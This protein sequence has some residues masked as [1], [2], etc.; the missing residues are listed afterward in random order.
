M[1]K[2]V[3]GLTGGIC[4][5]KSVVADMLNKLGCKIVD[6]D[7]ISKKA[8]ARGT[9]GERKLAEIF[10][11]AAVNGVI[12]RRKLKEIVF[13]DKLSLEKLN[14]A[15]HPIIEKKMKA[16]IERAG[17]GIILAVVPLLFE[18][19]FDK[20]CDFSV[21]ISCA[22]EI[23]IARLVKRDNISAELA[24]KILRN[25]FTDEERERRADFVIRN[26]GDIKYL[27]GQVERLFAVLPEKVKENKNDGI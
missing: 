25:Q 5:G 27:F 23:R 7:V 24:E 11:E 1:N 2:I 3:V 20:F 18:T 17:G 8:T 14:A 10:P 19:G 13:S 16:E 22:A 9:D 4:G 12:D 6:A 26:D 21:T 15:T